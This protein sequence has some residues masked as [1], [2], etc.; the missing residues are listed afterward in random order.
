MD[1]ILH[2]THAV[3]RIGERKLRVFRGHVA[4][5]D[6]PSIP[7]K[8][9]VLIAPLDDASVARVIAMFD[10]EIGPDVEFPLDSLFRTEV[11]TTR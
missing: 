9:L 4:E 1:L 8:A 5:A 10:A 6:A 7:I 3:T 11:T 2:P